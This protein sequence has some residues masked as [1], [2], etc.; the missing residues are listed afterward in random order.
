MVVLKQ[1]LEKVDLSIFDKTGR[2]RKEKSRGWE[3]RE[4]LKNNRKL[5]NIVSFVIIDDDSFDIVN[6]KKTL[7]PYYVKTSFKDGLKE[8]HIDKVLHVL[9]GGKVSISFISKRN[10]PDWKS[11]KYWFRK[12]V[13]EIIND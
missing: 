12:F 10:D 2:S 11:D 8:K 5:Y 1:K 3:I 6:H 4:W 13:Q 7:L 9:N